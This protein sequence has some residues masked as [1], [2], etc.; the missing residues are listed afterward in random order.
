MADHA[1]RVRHTDD[2]TEGTRF[3]NSFFSDR[4]Y[5]SPNE[6]VQA[7]RSATQRSKEWTWTA[8]L[9]YQ[10]NVDT[11]LYGKVTRGYKAGG[12][13]YAAPR[14]LTYDPEFVTSYELG[15]K[16]DFALA[17]MPARVNLNV[18]SMDYD[19]IQRAA[20][21]NFPIGGFLPDVNDFN[22]NGSTSDFVCTGPNGENFAASATCLDQG[23]VTFNADSARVRGFEMEA[24]IAP[25][26][27]LRKA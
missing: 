24:T 19:D 10:L 27:N 18:Y 20:G 5:S 14:A 7:A 26:D 11:L 8:G 21:D 15:I 23:A 13:N 25:V 16:A 12:F 9:D 17:T 1:G 4:V 2:E 3:T 22:G 6:F